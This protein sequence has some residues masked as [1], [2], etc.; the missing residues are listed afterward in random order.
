MLNISELNVARVPAG[1]RPR[2]GC[3]LGASPV[4]VFGPTDGL[5]S[6]TRS[7]AKAG[8]SYGFR[9]LADSCAQADRV[10]PGTAGP[11]WMGHKWALISPDAVIRYQQDPTNQHNALKARTAVTGGVLGSHPAREP[12]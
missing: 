6:T 3:G 2:C 4:A 1:S 11:R 10:T 9:V 12:V 8:R 7:G 5:G